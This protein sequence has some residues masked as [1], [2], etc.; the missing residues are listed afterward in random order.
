MKIS[1]I[2]GG[3]G[4]VGEHLLCV[5]GKQKVPI[6]G[7]Y[8]K[9][10][11]PK[12]EQLDIQEKNDVQKKIIDLQPSTIYMPA[13]TTNVDSCEQNPEASYQINVFGVRNVIE[14]ANEVGAK[15]V[16]FSSDY[17]FDGLSGPYTEDDMPNPISAYGR[18]KL[19]AE[20]AIFLQAKDF[21][22]IRTTVVYG[23]EM[24][25]KN[26]VYRL[27]NSLQKGQS[28][29]V[30]TDQIGSPTYAPNLALAVAELVNAG[31]NGVFNLAGSQI[32]SRY[33][34]ACE[35][36]RAFNLDEHLIR[37]VTTNELG[38][39]AARPMMAGMIISKA[40]SVLKTR[41]VSYK[42]GLRQMAAEKHL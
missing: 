29:S 33:E 39:F 38:Q 24:Q 28:V 31:V 10:P 6:L 14:A 22:I 42:E 18:Q 26:F 5:L 23:W 3:S 16:Y 11:L 36:A 17:I 21:L 30:P 7:T 19:M 15:L 8:Y 1:L 2:I 34:F 12:M 20:H 32:V 35:A 25:G 4:Q 40:E 37:P 13:S 27:I 9:H 41:L